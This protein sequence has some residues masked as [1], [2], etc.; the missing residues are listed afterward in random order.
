MKTLFVGCV[1]AFVLLPS[2]LVANDYA[3]LR[4][5]IS[6]LANW[7]EHIDSYQYTLKEYSQHTPQHYR[8]MQYKENQ[9]KYYYETQIFSPDP[10]RAYQGRCIA[11]D[12]QIGVRY[13]RDTGFIYVN[14][15]PYPYSPEWQYVQ[16]LFFPLRLLAQNELPDHLRSPRLTDIKAAVRDISTSDIIAIENKPL[17]QLA[18]L[19]VT[20]KYPLNVTTQTKAEA[21]AYFSI[22]DDYYPILIEVYQNAKLLE[23]H[24]VEK[25]GYYKSNQLRIPYPQKIKSA[26]YNEVAEVTSTVITEYSDVL[27]NSAEID[28]FEIDPSMARGMLDEGNGNRVITIP[29]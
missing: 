28:G 22:A 16:G 23:K 13:Q 5:I 12:G 18:C 8:T 17:G 26:Y 2:N 3:Y 25:I 15:K 24:E 27:F 4:D 6:H 29:K 1:A 14:K 19:Y 7:V 9:G 11:W 20:S 21:K 10:N